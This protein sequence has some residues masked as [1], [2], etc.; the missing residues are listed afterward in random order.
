M[1]AAL[2]LRPI[3]DAAEREILARYAQGHG[4]LR[5]AAGTG[6]SED[7]IAALIGSVSGFDRGRA[8]DAVRKWDT[9]KAH[10][11]AWRRAESKGRKR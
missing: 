8:R 7:G 5:L 9:A 1:T 4:T 2:A 10:E 6:R 3:S 11:A